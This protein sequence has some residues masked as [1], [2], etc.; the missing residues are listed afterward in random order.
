MLDLVGIAINMVR[1]DV[2]LRNQEYFPEP[3][4]THNSRCRLGPAIPE[5]DKSLPSE[6][7]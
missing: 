5:L 6:K 2:R 4:Y 3:V 1:G 7:A